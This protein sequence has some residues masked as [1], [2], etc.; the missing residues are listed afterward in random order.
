MLGAAI[1]AAF[2]AEPPAARGESLSAGEG[3]LFTAALSRRQG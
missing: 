3:L 1:H 2:G